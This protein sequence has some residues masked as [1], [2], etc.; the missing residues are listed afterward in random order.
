MTILNLM[1][2]ISGFTSNTKYVGALRLGLQGLLWLQK[3]W[4][5]KNRQS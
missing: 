2:N 1:D 3:S 5:Q 4:S